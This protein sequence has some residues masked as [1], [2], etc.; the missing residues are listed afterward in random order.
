[1]ALGALAAGTSY[2]NARNTAHKQDALLAQQI[3]DQGAL[4][5]KA[6]ARTSDLLAGLAKDTSGQDKAKSQ[7]Q[8]QQ[9]IAEHAGNATSAL[10]APASAS[11]A[12]KK[13]GSDAQLGITDYG[14]VLANL[15]SSIDAPTL[16]R[17]REARDYLDP[18]AT[19][20]GSIARQSRGSAFLSDLALRG[21]R[22]NP[23]LSLV[24]GL[25]GAA[26]GALTGG[27]GSALAGLGSAAAAQQGQP[28]SSPTLVS[29]LP[30]PWTDYA[31]GTVP[32]RAPFTPLLN[33]NG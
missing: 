11:A 29:D 27:W 13:A 21:V 2:V 16:Q 10:E 14:N 23:T 9:T 3:R 15:Q 30:N 32:G 12:Y 20:I 24:S 17:Q 6:N 5:K 19:D 28:Y 18:Y 26:S 4:Q 22:P 1:L 33:S 7:A 31:I 8:I 25:A